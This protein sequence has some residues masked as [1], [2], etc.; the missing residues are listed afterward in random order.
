MS[1]NKP[2]EQI[3]LTEEQIKAG[4]DNLKLILASIKERD[5]EVTHTDLEGM[6]NVLSMDKYLIMLLATGQY[7]KAKERMKELAATFNLFTILATVSTDDG[8]EQRIT[9]A[10]FLDL[11]HRGI[12]GDTVEATEKLEI[13]LT[14]ML[15]YADTQ[16]DLLGNPVTVKMLDALRT[17]LSYLQQGMEQAD[18]IDKFLQGAKEFMAIPRPAGLEDLLKINAGKTGRDPLKKD[19]GN[20]KVTFVGRLSIDEQKIND[21]LRLAFAHNNPYKATTGLNTLIELPFSNTMEMLG[22]PVTPDNKKRFSRQLRKEMLPTI[23]TQ[24]IEIENASGSGLRGY[25]GSDFA[26]DV[27]KDKIYFNLGDSYAK[28][29]STGALSQINYKSFRLGDQS[30]PLPYYLNLKLHTQYFHDGNR[31]RKDKKGNPQPTN[32]IL[33]VK[34]ILSFCS[35]MLPTYDYVQKTDRGHWVRRIRKPLEAALNEIQSTGIFKWEYCKKGLGEVTPQEIRTNDY[36][37][38]SNLYITFT[39]IPKEPDQTERLEHK[40]ERLEALE[41]KQALKDAETLIKAD[42]IKKRKARK[43]KGDKKEGSNT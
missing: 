40:Q 11:L 32:N 21:M 28:Y 5:D 6:Y 42:K 19:F 9:G 17:I 43:Q 18:E 38:W 1:D 13:L 26:V 24:Y 3:E 8:S 37:K 10:T 27:R 41:A 7:E 2:I 35:D 31:Q 39:L 14:S 29:L 34:T 22:R 16:P 36:V 33:Q 20:I 15:K 30:N 12:D 25:V 23:A 4:Q